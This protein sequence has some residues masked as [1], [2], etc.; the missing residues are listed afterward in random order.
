MESVNFISGTVLRKYLLT[1][2]PILEVYRALKRQNMWYRDKS[3]KSR[4]NTIRNLA[5]YDDYNS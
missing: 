4:E 5:N 2:K 3:K 1:M